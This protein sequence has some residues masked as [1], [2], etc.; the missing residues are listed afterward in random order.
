MVLNREIKRWWF[1]LSARSTRLPLD[2]CIP[3][4]S[5]A[6]DF[7]HGDLELALELLCLVHGEIWAW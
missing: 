4:V 7:G 5:E 3:F 2:A 1:R 6:W